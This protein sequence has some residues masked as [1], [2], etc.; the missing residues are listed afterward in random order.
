MTTVRL[1]AG[2]HSDLGRRQ[3]NQDRMYI[4]NELGV[5]VVA[6]GMGGHR[7]GG[8]AAEMV[9]TAFEQSPITTSAELTAVV[10]GVNEAIYIR[11]GADTDLAGM[12][13]TLTALALTEHD[14]EQRLSVA[15]VGDSRTYRMR[16]GELELLTEDHNFV[17]ELVRDGHLTEHDAKYHRNRSVLTRAI[18]VEGTVDVDL[19]EVLPSVGDRYLLCSDGLSGEV[20]SQ[21]IAATLRRFADPAEACRDL[22]RLALAAGS[23]D[24]ITA[25]VVD[26]VDD[27]G[28]ALA[29]SQ[30][31]TPTA[32]NS[33]PH[34]P[35]PLITR[36]RTNNDSRDDW[37][38]ASSRLETPA[39]GVKP[40]TKLIT[41]RTVAFASAIA[42]IGAIAW[43]AI[44]NAPSDA[45]APRLTTTVPA[46]TTGDTARSTSDATS[47]STSDATSESTSDA[48]SE[49]TSVP[50]TQ[51]T[52]GST[53]DTAT[54]STVTPTSSNV[55]P[56]FTESNAKPDA[57]TTAG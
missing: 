3:V 16:A 37:P 47:E 8:T 18:G 22:I 31:I 29:A 19:L 32:P 43:W 15:N 9:V 45:P 51:S 56:L 39:G 46:P 5:F 34:Q 30:H 23:K 54:E 13:T 36:D 44:T 35:Q 53:A 2:G 24:N 52:S 14:G 40:K 21:Q 7:G 33:Q 55:D 11:S 25:L 26:V 4:N 10:S 6:D 48:T 38:M 20:E 1:H 12:G 50:T 41:V 57:D 28:A 49:S 17:S 42:A 27:G